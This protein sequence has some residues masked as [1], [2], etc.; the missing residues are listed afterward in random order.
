MSEWRNT[1]LYMYPNTLNQ[2]IKPDCRAVIEMCQLYL[3]FSYL[4]IFMQTSWRTRWTILSNPSICTTHT[5]HPWAKSQQGGMYTISC[6][7]QWFLYLFCLIQ[8]LFTLLFLEPGSSAGY[9]K[10]FLPENMLILIKMTT[11]PFWLLSSYLKTLFNLAAYK[12]YL[13]ILNFVLPCLCSDQ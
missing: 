1:V 6:F 7:G 11:L 4:T 9:P 5:Q 8:S 12:L 13:H 10:G 2:T 3:K